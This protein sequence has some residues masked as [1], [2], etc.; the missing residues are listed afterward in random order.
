[1]LQFATGFLN[2]PAREFWK[3]TM[4]EFTAAQKGW[5]I[6]NGHEVEDKPRID[7]KRYDELERKVA[8]MN[9]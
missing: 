8:L 6:A 9:L 7:R 3:M 5:L 1:M 2:L 4:V